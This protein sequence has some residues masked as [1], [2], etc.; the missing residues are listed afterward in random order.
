M[1]KPRQIAQ[2][3]SFPVVMIAASEGGLAAFSELLTALPIESGM[4]FVLIQHFERNH[5]SASTAL[6][7]K[8]TRLPVVD[9]SHGMIVE[10]NHVYVSPPNSDMIILRGKL[11]LSPQ[12]KVRGSLGRIDAFSVALA[13]ERGSAAI[14]VVLSGNGSDGTYGLKVIKAAGGMTFA[15]EPISA[16]F[17]AMPTS[18]IAAGSVDFVLSLKKIAAELARIARSPYLTESRELPEGSDL[19]K[20][21]LLLRSSTG[22]DFRFYKQAIF[23]RRVARRM[24][25]RRI[26]SLGKYLPILKQAPHEAPELAADIFT[27]VTSFFR[28]PECFQALRK[29]VL[30][31]FRS[32]H[33]GADPLRIWIAG[34][35]TGEEVY[36]IAILLLEELGASA[37]HRKIQIFGTDIQERSVEQARAGVYSAAAVAGVSPTRLKRF[38]VKAGGG[39]Q[40]QK[41]VRDLCVF[42]RHDLTK[43][44]PFSRLDL[45]SCRNVLSDME[46]AFQTRLLT[47]FQYAVVPGGALFLGSSESVGEHT[48]VFTCE[49]RKHGIYVRQ[50]SVSVTRRPAVVPSTTLA[51][52][53]SLDFRGEAERVLLEHH[54]QSSN[55]ELTLLNDE[56]QRRNQEVNVLT[57]DLSN[58]LLGLDIPVLVLDS[59]LRIRRFTA[60]AGALLNLTPANVGRQFSDIASS[61]SVLDWQVLFSELKRSGRLIEREVTDQGGHRYSLRLRPN[62]SSGN[63][64]DGISVVLLDIDANKRALE[65]AQES[66][67]QALEARHLND[68]ILNSLVANV[69]VLNAGGTIV[70][71]NEAWNRF[72]RENG[73]PPIASVGPNANYI[74]VCKRAAAAGDKDADV[75]LSGIQDVLDGFRPFF[76]FEY[77][78]HYQNELRWFL[79][80]VTPLKGM[81]AGAVITHTNITDRKLAEIS[82]QTS[83]STIRSLLASSPQAVI[84]VDANEKIVFLNGNVDKFFGYKHDELLGQSVRL[85]IPEAARE[86]H[87]D[88]HKSYFANMQ[89]RPM[90]VDLSLEARRKDGTLFPVEI[91]LG[92]V[93]TAAG[94][95]AVA[96]VSDITERKRME[97]A[98]QA[99]AMEI[100]SLAANLLTAQEEERRR[101]SRELHDQ[102]CQQLASLAIDI[103]GLA[104]GATSPEDTTNQLRALQ[105]RIVKASDE[106]RHIAY[107]LHSSVLDDLGLVAS[108]QDL[109]KEFCNQTKLAVKFTHSP[110]PPAVPREVA[111]CLYRVAKESL[112]N[113]AKHAAA[114]HVALSLTV[115]KATIVLVIEDDGVGFSLQAVKGRGGLGLIG[116]EERVRLVKGKLSI[117]TQP[118]CGTRIALEIPCPIK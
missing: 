25:L 31:S 20:V 86:R 61:F 3:V 35:S 34:C 96:F 66:S 111:S 109:R 68:S 6:L 93:S 73:K 36:S 117:E 115:R 16:P 116:M 30:A 70:A 38:F 17:P 49:D 12:L 107:E 87:A 19:D 11:R 39:Y 33:C 113:I 48:D 65:Q 92:A 108:L 69:A 9:V 88:H 76:Q 46:P 104:V 85:L 18:A 106:T 60:A 112:Q 55:Q 63:D 29:R 41:F 22:I 58:L 99:H 83:E 110:L 5:A 44:P 78:C 23:R 50:S 14:G 79:M 64:I 67:K 94:K 47:A 72:A 13:E 84:A 89:S 26:A 32:K 100:R 37:A 95:I 27:H 42:A 7:A 59:E 4:A 15:Q 40:I 82:L 81:G 10:P 74:D 43:D 45:I 56:L 101:V 91:G 103:G 118:G 57:A 8:S 80:N 54:W 105:A 98:A 21:C 97:Q 51:D 28:D 53:A 77:P 62:K 24:A 1:P 71:T 75:A 102:I 90:G 114:K 2:P 52:S